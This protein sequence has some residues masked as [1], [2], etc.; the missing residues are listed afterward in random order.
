MISMRPK[1]DPG[2]KLG[3]VSFVC[4]FFNANSLWVLQVEI[5]SP[6]QSTACWG[7]LMA[8]AGLLRGV[9]HAPH[10]SGMCSAGSWPWAVSQQS[11][12]QAQR[13]A[14]RNKQRLQQKESK[15]LTWPSHDMP[16]MHVIPTTQQKWK[17]YRKVLIS[18]S[19]TWWFVWCWHWQDTDAEW[20]I[21]LVIV[22]ILW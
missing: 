6:L 1:R 16:R 15:A 14:E 12:P 21:W 9:L 18:I 10:L 13:K 19:R 22:D 3:F 20:N 2:V 17:Y 8:W 7:T 11:E 4:I 5:C